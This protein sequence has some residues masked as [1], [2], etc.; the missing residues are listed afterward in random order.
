V[1]LHF[2]H[3]G[4]GSHVG[5]G[6][7]ISLKRSLIIMSSPLEAH[8]LPSLRASHGTCRPL[9]WRAED[10]L[11]V[12]FCL[13]LSKCHLLRTAF[14]PSF[15][16]RAYDPF[17]QAL[18]C[19]SDKLFFQVSRLLSSLQC[20]FIFADFLAKALEDRRASRYICLASGSC[21]ISLIFSECFWAASVVSNLCFAALDRTSLW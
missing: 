2:L 8:L 10:R 17:A 4:S 19:P 21:Q 7:T 6:R 15:P 9:R 16:H 11:L 12:G 20:S 1:P 14:D 5:I 13:Q 3:V 18:F